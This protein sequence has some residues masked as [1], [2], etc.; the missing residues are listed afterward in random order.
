MDRINFKKQ[1]LLVFTK[2][3]AGLLFT[4]VYSQSK[5]GHNELI[6][7]LK[8]IPREYTYV[9]TNNSL[10]LTGEYIYYGIYCLN[11][12]TKLLT[13]LSKVAYV[14]LVDRQGK[15]IFKHKVKLNAG[16]GNG[17]FFI[18]T[19]T[20]SGSY[21]LLCYTQWMQN[22]ALK[23]IFQVDIHIVN[24]YQADQ[25]G[26]NTISNNDSIVSPVDIPLQ[27]ISKDPSTRSLL[28]PL[29][30]YVFYQRER[31]VLDLST[32]H[33]TMAGGYYSISVR[34]KNE[35]PT[36]NND[37]IDRY[38][39]SLTPDEYS[40][41]DNIE[42]TLFIPELRGELFQGKVLPKNQNDPIK[43]LKIGIS[44]P[45]DHP[46]FTISK[47]DEKGH[48]YYNIANYYSGDQV[49]FEILDD[50]NNKY[51]FGMIQKPFRDLDQ[52]HFSDLKIDLSMKDAILKRSISNQIENSYFKFK[53][54]STVLPRSKQIFSE[55]LRKT[56][57]LDD[58]TRFKTIRE[59]VFEYV[60]DVVIRRINKNKSVI[61]V[62]GYN[63]GT[64]SLAL[65]LVLIDGVIIQNHN[66]LLDYESA[67]IKSI[68]VLRDQF[69][70]GPQIYQ[71]AVLV[72]S[73]KGLELT[74]YSSL[75]IPNFIEFF[76]SLETKKY[77]KQSYLESNMARKLPDYRYQ[78]LWQPVKKFTANDLNLD[79]YTS[80]VSGIYEIILQ[81]ITSTGK[82]ISAIQ[83]FM[84]N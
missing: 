8:D 78:I 23:D 34:K 48:F 70:I 55:S 59:T 41:S 27:T 49:V 11:D 79:F 57:I 50:D 46:Y 64:N 24:P 4:S 44:I 18:P 58:F 56:Y 1:F 5:L 45:G 17:D 25:N 82:P 16:T 26:V 60:K 33:G 77:Y 19:S 12:Q 52:L 3:L 10:F 31:V 65:P 36:P 38:L 75:G 7:K 73:K 62:K 61:R 66:A 32:F 2:L 40:F 67:N 84:V 63:F 21:K 54:D 13:E 29:N 22:G 74:N 72:K 37:K 51:S 76:K 47:T 53:P 69:I 30:K 83:S 35:L 42:N 9:H 20:P 68:E 71:G 80:D 39:D 28:I 43:N 6:S 81:G 14:E 15:S